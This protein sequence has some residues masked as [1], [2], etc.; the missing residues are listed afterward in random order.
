MVYDAMVVRAFLFLR[1]FPKEF[2]ENGVK[3]V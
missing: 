2:N 3:F 1:D